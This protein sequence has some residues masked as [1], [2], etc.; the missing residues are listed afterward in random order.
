MALR[1]RVLGPGG[2]CCLIPPP[3][4]DCFIGHYGQAFGRNPVD[5]ATTKIKETCIEI[6]K[7][8]RKVTFHAYVEVKGRTYD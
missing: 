3:C 2:D 1:H 5:I 6:R 4:S 8:T 7:T